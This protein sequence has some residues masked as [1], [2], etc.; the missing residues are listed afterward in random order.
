[1]LSQLYST[2]QYFKKI[3]KCLEIKNT[4]IKDSLQLMKL[5]VLAARF[6]EI[7]IKTKSMY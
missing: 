2:N 5:Y 6:V 3:K 7:Y 1:M 4:S